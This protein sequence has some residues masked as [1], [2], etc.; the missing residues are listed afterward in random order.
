MYIK[1]KSIINYYKI[2]I[3]VYQIKYIIEKSIFFNIKV[4]TNWFVV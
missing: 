3:L 1:I 2:R 4:F